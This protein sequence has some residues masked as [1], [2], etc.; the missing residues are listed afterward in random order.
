LITAQPNASINPNGSTSFS[1]VFRPTGA[2]LRQATITIANNDTDEGPYSFTIQGTGEV[3]A[4]PFGHNADL[5]QDVN[6]DDRVSSND[7]LILVNSLLR[8]N[9]SPLV[10][11]ATPAAAS[12]YFL[13]VSGDGR[14][15]TSDLLMVV[16]YILRNSAAPLAAPAV[17]SAEQ[18]RAAEPLAASAV[19]AAFVL[20]DDMA[21]AAKADSAPQ[22]VAVQ[23]AQADSRK[24]AA[25]PAQLLTA[26]SISAVLAADDVEEAAEADEWDLLS[27]DI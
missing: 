14:V 12:P 1:I 6:A 4:S 11:S 23:S 16:N 21:D 18:T 15:S 10:A 24:V 20:F 3:V 27:L 5:P 22:V 9:A 13:D 17:A 19:D 25:A 8:N 26:S 2:G 7:V